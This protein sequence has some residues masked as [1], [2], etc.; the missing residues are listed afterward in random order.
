MRSLGLMTLALAACATPNQPLARVDSQDFEHGRVGV[1]GTVWARPEELFAV[2][3]NWCGG[4]RPRPLRC[5]SQVF[6]ASGN[7]SPGLFGSSGG[8]DNVYGT[9][10]MYACELPTVSVDGGT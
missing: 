8:S 10:C 7:Y 3:A 2:A 1:C 5:G 6:G 4:Y 9:C